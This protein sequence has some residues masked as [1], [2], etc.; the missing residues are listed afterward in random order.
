MNDTPLQGESIQKTLR[1]VVNELGTTTVKINSLVFGERPETPKP[2][3]P[4]A[5]DK[6]TQLR[7]EIQDITRSLREVARRLEITG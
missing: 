6:L 1:M 3:E 2:K 4:F 7:N 5:G